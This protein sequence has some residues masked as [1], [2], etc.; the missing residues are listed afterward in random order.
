MSDAIRP[1][2][3]PEHNHSAADGAAPA[4]DARQFS[5]LSLPTA[6]LHCIDDGLGAQGCNDHAYRTL[7]AL[8]QVNRAMHRALDGRA[9]YNTMRTAGQ[10]RVIRPL[11]A[12]IRKVIKTPKDL[13]FEEKSWC[14][15]EM[16]DTRWRDLCGILPYFA[17]LDADDRSFV[18]KK[19]KE[20]ITELIS[21]PGA[22]LEG[23]RGYLLAAF[24]YIHLLD[25][26][27]SVIS[28]ALE[29]FD[30][31]TFSLVIKNMNFRTKSLTPETRQLV[32]DRGLTMLETGRVVGT[33]ERCV[34]LGL[35]ASASV[36]DQPTR[37][38][39][40]RAEQALGYG[41]GG[42]RPTSAMALPAEPAKRAKT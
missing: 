26:Q 29:K 11:M 6:L 10:Q 5:L 16:T 32:F 18:E 19:I 7:G 9:G 34:V 13:D 35:Q 3:H 37:Q 1:R 14:H 23:F 8:R 38:R 36:M 30:D 2:P 17:L 31:V 42:K 21:N 40:M 39:L 33:Y 27:A 4:D 24:Q 25:R 41:R 22:V 15:E 12:K 20:M 28:L